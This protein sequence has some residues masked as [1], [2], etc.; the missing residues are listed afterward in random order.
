MK[1]GLFLIVFLMSLALL[2]LV[3]MQVYYIYES[4]NLKSKLFDR[5]VMSA[6][7]NVSMKIEKADA[8]RFMKNR[9]APFDLPELPRFDHEEFFAR[10]PGSGQSPGN[11][12]SQAGTAVLPAIVTVQPYKG[13]NIISL[14]D[15]DGA[16]HTDISFNL[17]G[18]NRVLSLPEF[19]QF[20]ENSVN[21]E[22]AY[23]NGRMYFK[24]SPPFGIHAAELAEKVMEH[25]R[26]V[27]KQLSGGKAQIGM[28]G[29]DIRIFRILD[30]GDAQPITQQELQRIQEQQSAAMKTG[31]SFMPQGELEKELKRFL[32]SLENFKQRVKVF[33]ELAAEMQS[34]QVP[35]GDRINPVVVD[36]LLKN[37]LRNQGIDL[38][39][40]IEIRRTGNDSLIFASYAD[41]DDDRPGI[42]RTAL[43][44]QDLVNGN[45]GELIV[46]IPN[47]DRYLMHKMTALMA[48]SGALILVILACFSAT[49]YAIIRQKKLSRMKSDFINNMTHEFK[50]PVA[51]IMLASEALKDEQ[52]IADSK[53]VS[54]YAG[55]I[56]DENLRMGGYVERVLNMA[57]LEKDDFTIGR[58]EIA[59]NDL[60][61]G[62]VES[63]DLQ[64][65][66]RDTDLQLDLLASDDRIVG[67]EMHLSNLI[68][69]LVDN[70]VKYSKD[71]PQIRIGTVNEN[72]KLKIVVADKGIGMSKEQ[73]KKIFEKFYRV[74][75]GNLHD[76]KGFGL[77][78]SYVNS[79]VK[80]MDGSIRVRS[81]LN[82][83]SEFEI[84]FP[85]ASG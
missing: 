38:D 43:F 39:Y 1:K 5:N 15:T 63:M 6:L 68:Y 80:L 36:S 60:V 69:N 56:Y 35:I 85:L 78:L 64:L 67:D 51:T 12:P 59:V 55:I 34:M 28:T 31:G 40:A 4:H 22:I 16:F 73:R 61:S 62:V 42:Y 10:R 29:S 47:K 8:V 76:V 23:R 32:D 20:L 81:E 52:M 48:S 58:D 9:T 2:G 75:S 79:I 82:K 41:I 11:G 21:T 18:F 3:G 46:K 45:S 25:H 26:I 65:K 17:Y 50:T 83:G 44:P 33:E 7:N 54:R 70:A 53:Q 14:R 37:E 77:G 30:N 57:R 71:R 19:E 49:V 27:E 66:Q 13:V 72:N 84:T 24:K 74:Q